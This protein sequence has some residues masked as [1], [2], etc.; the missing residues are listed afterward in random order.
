VKSGT[1]AKA[2]DFVDNSLVAELEQQRLFQTL[3][4]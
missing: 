1:V 3:Y 4:R 2:T